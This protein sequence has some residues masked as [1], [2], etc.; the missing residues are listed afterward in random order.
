[1]FSILEEPLLRGLIDGNIPF[2]E[3]MNA[4]GIRVTI[5][6]LPSSILGF[7]YVSR[8]GY[9]HLILNG[10]INYETQC[11]TFV[12]EIKHITQDMPKLGYMIGLD[13]QRHD[14]EIKADKV[15]EKAF[16]FNHQAN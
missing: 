7:T 15:A 1:M 10:N 4:F 5:G 13:M 3:V 8:K 11:K 6:N 9:Y 14:F 2:C 12:H 16:Y